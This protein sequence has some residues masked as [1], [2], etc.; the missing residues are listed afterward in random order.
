M[1]YFAARYEFELIG[2]VIPGLTSQGEVSAGELAELKEHIAAD[3]VAVIFAEIG[4]PAAVTEAIAKETGAKVVELPSH[5]L[6]ADG[7]YFSFIR[8][9]SSTIAGALR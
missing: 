2:A 4:T 7:S 1:G 9:I 3:G 8:Q 6:P 5:N